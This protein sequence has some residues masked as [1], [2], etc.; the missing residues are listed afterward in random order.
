MRCFVACWPDQATRTRLDHV[1]RSLHLRHPGARRMQADN[2]H[3]T[4]AFVGE[5]PRSMAS[6]V[7]S[8]MADLSVA[9]FAWCVDRLGRFDRAHIVWAGGPEEPRLARLAEQVRARLRALEVPFDRKP[10]AAHV[11]LLRDVTA[12]EP[13][14]ERPELNE[15]IEPIHWP[16]DAARLVVSEHDAGGA[17]RYRVVKPG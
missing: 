17:V 1:A 12:R 6:E 4:L 8:A 11:T 5:L 2:L 14:L 15:A 13:L 7:A 3:L 10:F 9:A 16:I